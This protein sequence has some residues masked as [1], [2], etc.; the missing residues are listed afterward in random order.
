MF[1]SEAAEDFVLVADGDAEDNILSAEGIDV[2][3]VAGEDVNGWAIIADVD[4]AVAV[5]G[6]VVRG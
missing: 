6:E 1:I 2:A 5:D 4:S 3:A